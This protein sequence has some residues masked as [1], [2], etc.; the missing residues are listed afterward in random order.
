MSNKR[1]LKNVVANY[2]GAFVN[3]AMPI[4]AIPFLIQSL[5]A[6]VWGLVAFV[7]LMV[8]LMT[9]LNTGVAQAM[10]REFG[11]RWAEPGDGPL[12]TALLLRGYE[13]IYWIVA[14]VIGG[15]LLPFSGTIAEAWLNTSA[16]IKHLAVLAPAAAIGVF[17]SVL[18]SSVYRGTL[19]A[20]QEHVILNVIRSAATVLKFGVGVV[21]VV[22][23]GSVL[24]YMIV[25]VS[26]SFLECLTL[27]FAAWRL[28]PK[29]RSEVPCD[30]HEA[31]ISA[32][33][34][35][36]MSLIVVIGVAGTQLDRFLVSVILPVEQLGIYSLAVSLALG[37]LQ[38]SYPVFTAVLP[39][40]V[41]L[42]KDKAQRRSA[43]LTF[44][45]LT[46]T[47]VGVAALIYLLAGDFLLELWLSDT[48]L[49]Q[50]VKSPLNWLMVGVALNTLYNIGYTNW[51]SLGQ[52]RAAAIINVTSLI[53]AAILTPI[54]INIWGI[55]GAA[56]SFVII[57]AIGAT[58]AVAWLLFAPRPKLEN[59]N[60]C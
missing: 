13:R 32:R 25:L 57:N 37:I 29:P 52:V 16:E 15:V 31:M 45:A 40:L 1:V 47:T 56:S 30:F 10:V 44:L 55:T 26:V 14:L 41:E 53:V 49:A 4:L 22:N 36:A 18:P 8:I 27:A 3:G 24:A 43:N 42:E 58:Y 33:Y 23:T 21:I 59:K 5:G 7:N 39:R 48:A 50:Q 12:R 54:A 17:A 20:L 2:A 51:V 9:M 28:M 6:E 46:C 60:P 19:Q 11:K 38:F 35:I 34:S